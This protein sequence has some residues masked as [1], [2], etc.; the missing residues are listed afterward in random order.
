MQAKRNKKRWRR[1]YSVTDSRRRRVLFV[2]CFNRSW[3]SLS[4]V[5]VVFLTCSCSVQS[6]RVLSTEFS[7]FPDISTIFID[8]PQTKKTLKIF[9][10]F[11]FS[12]WCVTKVSLGHL[13]RDKEVEIF[14]F[15]TKSFT[16]VWEEFWTIFRQS[17]EVFWDSFEV[18]WVNLKRK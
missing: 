14:E 12:F 18:E 1:N 5:P 8:G 2:E 9:F 17:F 4:N 3:S 16:R 15:T 6:K 13:W 10:Y 11:C 7:F